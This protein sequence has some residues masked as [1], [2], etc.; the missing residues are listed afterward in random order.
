MSQPYAF[1]PPNSILLL[2]LNET[3]RLFHR[4]DAVLQRHVRRPSN[5]AGGVRGAAAA[6]PSFVA[7]AGSAVWRALEQ[8]GARRARVELLSLAR[9]YEASRPGFATRMREV[10][11]RV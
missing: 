7:R 9:Q 1:S 11:R 6:S 10:A 5:A 8:T 2:A 3:S 4:L